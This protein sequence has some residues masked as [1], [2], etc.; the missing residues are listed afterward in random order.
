MLFTFYCQVGIN[1]SS[2]GG[3]KKPQLLI[4]SDWLMDISVSILIGVGEPS[5]L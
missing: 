4:K 3:K 5:P 1:Q 2:F